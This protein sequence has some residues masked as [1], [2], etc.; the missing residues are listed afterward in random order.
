MRKFTSL[1]SENKVDEIVLNSISQNGKWQNY[2]GQ[3]SHS[4][5][6]KFDHLEVAPKVM[7]AIFII[8]GSDDKSRC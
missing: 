3:F 6:F 7:F 8:L 5:S 1:S 4:K 2:N